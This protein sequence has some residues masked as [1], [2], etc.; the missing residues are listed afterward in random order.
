MDTITLAGPLEAKLRAVRGSGFTQIMLNAGDIVGHPDGESAAIAAVRASGLRVTGFQVLRDFEG[1]SGHLHAHK[2]DMAKAMI[3]MCRALDTNVLLACSSTSA[4]AKGDAEL[5]VK[6]LRKLAML[7]V[8]HGIRIAYEALSWGR[9]VNEFSQ[10]WDIVQQ[11][12]RANLGLC[13]DSFHMLANKTG[14]EGLDSIDPEKIFLVQLSDFLWQ[15]IRSPEDRIDT[16]RHYR[17]FPGEG[18]HSAELRELV[19]QVDAMGYRG[20]YSFEVF[21]DDYR[22]LPLPMVAERARSSVK[23]I[24]GVVARRSLPS[25]N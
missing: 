4:H 8:P 10:A 13:L 20:D 1:L 24:T 5:L 6:D 12:D 9:Y 21:S 25:R 3:Q 7:A 16:A 22:N 15:E 18:V 11:A 23:W 19:R 17:V 2:V 14:L